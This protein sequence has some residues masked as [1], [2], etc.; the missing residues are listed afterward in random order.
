[1]HTLVLLG[2]GDLPAA[3]KTNAVSQIDFDPDRPLTGGVVHAPIAVRFANTGVALAAGELTVALTSVDE[4]L[5][6]LARIQIPVYRPEA[7]YLK[8]R[9]LRQDERP[10]EAQQI[11]L[12]ALAESEAMGE[13]RMRWRILAGLA[14]VAE[15]TRKRPNG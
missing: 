2:Q 11:W 4:L 14:E 15:M 8:G 1:M 5:D 9:I 3:Q 12:Q 7:L 13:R 10:A 6:Y